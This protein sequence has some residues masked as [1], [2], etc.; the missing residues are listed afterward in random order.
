LKKLVV[1]ASVAIKWYLP[2]Q[3]SESAEKLMDD[4]YEFFAPD[5]IHSEIGNILW[6]R[7]LKNE[8]S[9]DKALIIFDAFK[10][11]PIE[12]TNS[13]RIFETAF[14]IAY[15]IKRS[16][17]DSLYIALAVKNNCRMVTADSKLYNALNDMALKKHVLWIED[18]S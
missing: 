14:K 7:A 5:I 18:I 12:I 8:F 16:F 10:S 1:D 3:Y 2:E 17:Y 6:K 13:H 4:S 15:K 11:L 9:P